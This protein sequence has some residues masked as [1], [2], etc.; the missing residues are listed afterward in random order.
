MKG[1]SM[2]KKDAIRREPQLHIRIS[3]EDLERLDTLV[4]SSDDP[5]NSRARVIRELIKNAWKSKQELKIDDVTQGHI[6][7][8][9][10]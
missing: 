10:N 3:D 8:K 9:P 4:E 7:T 2:K 6:S 1:E 5:F